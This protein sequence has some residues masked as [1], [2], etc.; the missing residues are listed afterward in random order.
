MATKKR[1]KYQILQKAKSAYC[2]GKKNKAEVKKC[3]TAYVKDA[4]KKGQTKASAEAKAR[5][6]L[7]AGCKMTAR[8]SGTKKKKATR[9][10]KRR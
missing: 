3:A 9:R 4:T 8:L 1:T 5:R 6:V 2:K 7:N 10:R